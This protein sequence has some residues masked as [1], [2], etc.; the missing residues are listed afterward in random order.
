[1]IWQKKILVK[2]KKSFGWLRFVKNN[3]IISSGCTSKDGRP[4]AEF[5]ALK[6]KKNFKDSDLYVTLEP[7]SHFGKTPPC[8]DLIIKKV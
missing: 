2:Q 5:N 4:H 7:C 8:T 6:S 3:T 1:M